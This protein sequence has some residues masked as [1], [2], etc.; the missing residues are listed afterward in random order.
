HLQ[1]AVRPAARPAT[2]TVPSTGI[3]RNVQDVVALKAALVL[4]PPAKANDKP[5]EAPAAASPAA[6]SPA[7]AATAAAPSGAAALT[8][9]SVAPEPAAGRVAPT[10]EPSAAGARADSASS[11]SGKSAGGGMLAAGVLLAALAFAAFHFTRRRA[12]SSRYIQIIESASLGPKRSIVVARVGD[13]TMVLGASE[14]GITLL[15]AL[16]LPGAEPHAA[17]TSPAAARAPSAPIVARDDAPER[18]VEQTR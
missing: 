6:A 8:T 15:K 17:A 2:R 10:G 16:P 1:Q 14:A 11:S 12:R 9:T 18:A 5:A 7:K 13:A 3:D 4:Q